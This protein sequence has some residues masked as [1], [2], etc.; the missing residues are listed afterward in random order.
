MVA[1]MGSEEFA[2]LTPHDFTADQAARL[3]QDIL[4]VLALPFANTGRDIHL[5]ASMGI[6]NYPTDANTPSV[7]QQRAK[8]SVYRAKADGGNRYE[9]FNEEMADAVMEHSAIRRAM[10]PALNNDEFALHYQPKIDLV[11]GKL[12]GLEALIRWDSSELGSV[13]PGKFIPLAEQTPF[14]QSLGDWIL[15]SAC[16]QYRAWQE[17]GFVPPPIAVNIAGP[18]LRPELL[19]MIERTLIKTRMDTRAL[20]LELTEN[21]LVQ[22]IDTAVD[23]L[24]GLKKLG[25]SLSIDDFGTG[26]SSLSY[27][28]RFPVDVLKVDQS[29]V[30]DIE[31]SEGSV[32]IVRAT[33]AMAHSMNLGIV[34]EGVETRRHLEILQDMGCDQIQGYLVSRP[35]PAEEITGFFDPDWNLST[36]LEE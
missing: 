26:Y 19:E 30:R 14:I 18:Q 13:S 34:A 21:S 23:L 4:S 22:N 10:R 16:S 2:V 12:A 24:N 7:L 29:F 6:A 15:E 9:F 36:A 1:Y 11:S 31:E 25:L 3:A 33:I 28:Q 20:H 5:T 8:I 35:R 32:A 27:L 17:L